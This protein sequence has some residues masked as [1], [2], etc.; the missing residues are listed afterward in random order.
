MGIIMKRKGKL[1]AVGLHPLEDVIHEIERAIELIA[2]DESGNLNSQPILNASS[3]LACGSESLLI[4][5][6]NPRIEGQGDLTPGL[7]E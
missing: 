6:V 2:S 1:R 5:P 7:E 4:E 3:G